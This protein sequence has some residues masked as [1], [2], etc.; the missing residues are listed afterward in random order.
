MLVA[1]ALE[2]NQSHQPLPDCSAALGS[3]LPGYENTTDFFGSHIALVQ[4]RTFF[5]DE[6]QHQ[7]A[8]QEGIS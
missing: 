2:S 1:W 3:R 4:L 7:E 8:V 6:Y 5:A